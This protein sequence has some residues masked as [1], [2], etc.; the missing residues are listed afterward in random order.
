MTV[1]QARSPRRERRT[2]RRTTGKP[3]FIRARDRV[4]TVRARVA[5]LQQIAA[6]RRN[7]ASPIERSGARSTSPAERRHGRHSVSCPSHTSRWTATNQELAASRESWGFAWIH[8]TLARPT[9]WC[10]AAH[11]HC[12][13]GRPAGKER[14]P[15]RLSTCR[16]PSKRPY[17]L[18][19]RRWHSDRGSDL[20]GPRE[21]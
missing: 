10:R 16:E 18:H 9:A 3:R 4:A 21:D 2:A 7:P 15:L 17:V 20:E 14:L 1:P 5:K 19:D 8:N 12:T 6:A 13:S 11:E